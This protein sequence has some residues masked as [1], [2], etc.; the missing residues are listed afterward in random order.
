MPDLYWWWVCYIEAVLE[1]DPN[2]K[3][4]RIYEAIAAI[5]QRLL[6]P[7]EL[8]SDEAIALKVANA[9]V[10]R[11]KSEACQA[12]ICQASESTNQITDS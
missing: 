1:T 7:I 6:S 5:E 10:A 2:L 9:G 11:L 12:F 4:G 3:V 8:G